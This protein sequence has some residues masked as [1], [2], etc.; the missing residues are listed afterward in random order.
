LNENVKLFLTIV[1]NVAHMQ[2]TKPQL[3]EK[4]I[5]TWQE[6][7]R[8]LPEIATEFAKHFFAR[9]SY[10]LL[11]RQELG[12]LCL[13]VKTAWQH[14]SEQQKQLPKIKL[15]HKKAI[16]SHQG[17][18]WLITIINQDRPYIVDSI[19][20][21]M[22]RLG[23][24]P[25]FFVHPV[26]GVERD[27]KGEIKKILP[28][29]KTRIPTN[30]IFESMVFIQLRPTVD[31]QKMK[32]FAQELEHLLH[33]VSWVVDDHKELAGRLKELKKHLNQAAIAKWSPE[34]VEDACNFLDWLENGHFIFLGAR[35]FPVKTAPGKGEIFCTVEDAAVASLGLLKDEQIANANDLVPGFSRARIVP[36]KGNV[37]SDSYPLVTVMKTNHRSP[38]HRHSRIDSIEVMDWDQEGKIQGIYQFIGIFTKDVF[39]TSAF[40]VPILAR[41]IQSVFDR[42]GLN[43]NW[44]DGRAL[45]SILDSIPRDEMFYH[46]E[47]ELAAIGQKVL[48]LGE[49]DNLALFIRPDH[50]GRY[51]T[52]MVYLPRERYAFHLKEKL[53]AILAQQLH[54][55]VSSSVAHV[56]DLPFARVI[57]VLTFD[58]PTHLEVNT[59]ALEVLLTE[60]SLSWQD[61]LERHLGA[62]ESEDIAADLWG[63][64]RY[65]FPI[66]YQEKFTVAEAREDIHTLE[67]ITS[68]LP[69]EFHLYEKAQHLRVKIFHYSEAVSLSRLLPILQNMGLKV[70]S[71]MTFAIDCLKNKQSEKIYIHDFEVEG[72]IPADWLSH[73]EHLRHA[74]QQI[75]SGAVENDG[76][77]QFILWAKLT[78]RQVN[79]LRAYSR[80]LQQVKLPYSTSYVE[81]ALG[82]YTDITKLLVVLFE[83][84]FY[85]DAQP[86][87]TEKVYE[88][89]ERHLQNVTRLDQELIFRR[90][91]NAIQSTIR[92][93]YFQQTPDGKWKDYISLKMDCAK[94]EHLPEPRPLY[95][96]FVFSS[97]M[98]AIHLRGGKVARGGIRW[99]DRFEDFRTEVL[100][101]MKAQMVKNSVIVPLG[102]KGGFV[103]KRHAQ[104]TER[105]ALMEEVVSCYQTMIRG[106]LDVTDNFIEGKIVP[107]EQVRRYDDD[108]PYLVVAAD[109]GTATFSDIANAISQ[110]YR[111]W[112]DDAFASGGSAGYDHKK[113]AI[114]SRGAW[115]SAKRHF[116]ELGVN[117]HQ[118]P[119]TVVGIGDMAGDVFGNGMLRSNKTKLIA[120]FNHQHIFLDPNPDP[121]VSFQERERLFHLPRSTWRDYNPECISQG[122]GVYER[123]VKRIPLSPEIKELLK[124]SQ[125][126]ITPDDLIQ[127]ILKA[128]VDLMWFGGIGTFI[129]ASSESHAEVGDNA[130][131]NLR[132][133]AKDLRAKVI[134][135]GANLGMT[136]RARIEY[137]L[138]GGRVNTDAIDNSAGVDCSDHEVNIKILFSSLKNAMPREERDHLLRQMTDEVAQLVLQDN[139]RQTQILTVLEKQSPQELHNYQV[140]IKT[141]ETEVNLKPA[142]EYLPDEET[143]ERRRLKN[144]GLTRPEL[145]VLLAYSKIALYRK[146]VESPLVDDPSYQNYLFKYFP[147]ILQKRFA[148]DI[149][150]HPLRREIIATVLA[151]VLINRMGPTF[152]Y[153]LSAITGFSTSKVIHSFF[154]IF[155]LLNYESILDSLD[156]LDL[157]MRT[158]L[159]TSAYLEVM[160]VIRMCVLWI[161]HRPG[162][163]ISREAIDQVLKNLAALVEGDSQLLISTKIMEFHDQ[164]LPHYLAE[165]LAVLPFYPTA[166]DI[167]CLVRGTKQL[168]PTAVAYFSLQAH[169]GFDWL[170]QQ[171]QQLMIDAEWQK[172]AQIGLID[173]LSRILTALTDQVMQSSQTL[174]FKRWMEHN[175]SLIFQVNQII[176][177]LKA[178]TRPDFGLVA[179]GVR[180]LQRMIGVP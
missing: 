26:L 176:Q 153:D 68:N 123:S 24:K 4:I 100:G 155:E 20:S 61:L 18:K 144:K 137:A 179:Y 27:K 134:V 143:L 116:R 96:V 10:Y 2:E 159:Q 162:Y 148:S 125:L 168:I 114:T 115:E 151:N 91:M 74:F 139:Y 141:L 85:I 173:D 7:E 77:N 56:G 175:Q 94:L 65:S 102:S 127:A 16:S 106:L 135:E 98:E 62:C 113:I 169:L 119:F 180:Q 17:P 28:F 25:Q 110:E 118:D 55:T 43:P 60:A 165:N 1:K 160:Q 122:G 103:V 13:Y 3:I 34:Q 121:E 172:G 164:G 39:A 129:K 163:H 145:A 117:I 45:I 84:R 76:L 132:V 131:N 12:D 104:F 136:Q 83:A 30:V 81:S 88:I 108:D 170:G 15:E 41:K 101:L 90:F 54:G 152:V 38:V 32:Q 58:K 80:Y 149:E 37:R 46:S 48:Q 59:E 66:S 150:Q 69:I 177:L 97:H 22:Q 57:F 178:S 89:L 42:S 47:E 105:S 49:Y 50:Y 29:S 109:K 92:T 130:N 174:N 6:S 140:L 142:L 51:L 52:V 63:R 87:D 82:Q 154:V 67:R 111:F 78:V 35:Y 36:Q 5:H 124:L 23:I 161:L 44:H 86:E 72:S 8:Y 171:A 64:Y 75:W 156:K 112:L 31:E 11:S 167:A 133:D 166:L 33:Q 40:Q 147:S 53:G 14:F 70:A 95:E 128:E 9:A 126:D 158:E 93:N 73:H 99:S 120:A 107:P 138:K 157:L 79:L 71:E 21:L 146:I 19:Q